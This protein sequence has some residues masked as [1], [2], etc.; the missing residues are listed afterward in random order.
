MF[1]KYF[2]SRKATLNNFQS[3][4]TNSYC[5]ILINRPPTDV[6]R[7]RQQME[8]TTH[9]DGIPNPICQFEEVNFPEY[10]VD[11]IR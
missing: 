4:R 5:I 8:I 11:E 9:G 7:Y 6:A 1:Y 10:V 3:F 2:D